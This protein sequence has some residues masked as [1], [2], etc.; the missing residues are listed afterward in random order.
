MRKTIAGLFVLL[1]L[2]LAGGPA[3]AAPVYIVY[4]SGGSQDS[5]Q[6]AMTQLGFSFVVRN[7][8]NPVTA[9]DLG[10]TYAAVVV[11]WSAGGFDMSGLDSAVLTAGITGNKILTGHDADFHTV[12]GVAAAASFMT[13][14]VEFA[15][16]SPGNTGILAFPVFATNPFSYL[17][18]PWGINAFD[19]LTSETITAI[20]ADG[21]ASGLYSGLTLATLSNWG[22][23]FH[24][25]FTAF[26]PTFHSFELG[27]PPTDTIVTIGTT[28]TPLPPVPEPASLI[29][30]GTGV[31][32]LVA[33]ARRRRT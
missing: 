6:Q 29:L 32:G 13:R 8:A 14:A 7:A 19:S 15:G 21:V 22:Q 10:G 16:G 4:D 20:T 25:G 26:D 11:G 2:M 33:R 30:L 3:T 24:A 31:A 27:Q 12:A 1:L 17:P 9:A 28:V 18:A 5:I 23:S